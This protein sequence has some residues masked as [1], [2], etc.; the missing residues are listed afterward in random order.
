MTSE[1]RGKEEGEAMGLGGGIR[2]RRRWRRGEG[3]RGWQGESAGV[4]GRGQQAVDCKSTRLSSA[5][6]NPICPQSPYPQN[7][8]PG[9][10]PPPVLYNN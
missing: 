10:T 6:P 2:R 7:V 9:P 8:G 4:S 1:A 3:G 5:L